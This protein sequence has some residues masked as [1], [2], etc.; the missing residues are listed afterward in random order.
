[1]LGSLHVEMAAF[2]ALG[3]WLAGSGWT[4]GLVATEVSSSGIADSFLT[5]SHVTRT[6][7]THQVTAV[8]L[9]IFQKNAYGS[10]CEKAADVDE[11]PLSFLR[12]PISSSSTGTEFFLRAMHTSVCSVA[13][14]PSL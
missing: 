2:K 14:S 3:N 10:Y 5:A 1:M 7:R 8:S 12:L 4:A 9:Y 6:R 13:K 11:T